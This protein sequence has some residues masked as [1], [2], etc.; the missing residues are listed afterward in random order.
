MVPLIGATLYS[1]TVSHRGLVDLSI[2]GDLLQGDFSD[3]YNSNEDDNA[4]RN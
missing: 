4:Y 2:S 3:G 1:Y